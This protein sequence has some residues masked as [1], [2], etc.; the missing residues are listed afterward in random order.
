MS[1]A[2]FQSGAVAAA[3]YSNVHLLDWREFQEMFVVRWF[4]NFFSP[5]IAE[6]AD[7]LHEYTE[8]MNSRIFRKVDALP[9]ERRERLK[10]LSEKHAPLAITNF[11]FHPV[12]L[13]NLLSS[14][15][16]SI[17][18]LPLRLS[19][20]PDGSKL[21]GLV[22]DEILDAT[23]L[24]HLLEAKIEHSRLAIAEFDEVFGERA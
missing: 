18:S 15:A 19:E 17:P 16:T 11:A 21:A 20:K 8:P 13:D 10:V 5:T 12:V 7:A 4:H 24:R 6:E 22:S 23:A 3:A 2:G 9:E 1:S 14:A